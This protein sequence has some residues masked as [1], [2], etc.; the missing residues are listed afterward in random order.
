VAD[1]PAPALPAVA[2][3][4]LTD[5]GELGAGAS[6]VIRRMRHRDGRWL[7]VKRFRAG[8]TSDGLPASEE[9]AWCAAGAHPHLIGVTAQVA[10]VPDGGDAL[11]MDLLD[12]GWGRLGH[13]PSL[14]SCSRDTFPAGTAFPPAVAVRIAVDIAAAL[15][16]LHQR[17]LVHGDLYT[18]NILVRA[19]GTARL[20]D[21]GAAWAP[22]GDARPWQRQEI[23]AYGHLLDDLLRHCPEPPPALVALRDR[24]TAMEPAA[25]PAAAELVRGW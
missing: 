21:F 20:G 2:W 4:D 13:P 18:H 3:A 22:P 7:A 17:G 1:P 16:H 8:L 14:E 19:D 25:R 11:A 6:G 15:V 10:G 24:C 12:D 9:A 23:L 5:A